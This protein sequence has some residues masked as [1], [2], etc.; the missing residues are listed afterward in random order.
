MSIPSTAALT[1]KPGGG[2]TAATG[3]GSHHWVSA[4][5]DGLEEAIQDYVQCCKAG[6]PHDMITK[7]NGIW[8][9]F[10]MP[11]SPEKWT[12]LPALT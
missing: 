1:V 9:T 11:V 8:P 3:P 12:R 4:L 7:S 5:G 10:P 6:F 2:L